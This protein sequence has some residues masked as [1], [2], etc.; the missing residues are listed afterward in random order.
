MSVAVLGLVYAYFSVTTF[1]VGQ[2]HEELEGTNGCYGNYGR[3][4][5]RAVNAGLKF[6]LARLRSTNAFVS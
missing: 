2:G 6:Y 4:L 1:A 5:V 3:L